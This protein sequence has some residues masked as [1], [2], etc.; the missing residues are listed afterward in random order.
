MLIEPFDAHGGLCDATIYQRPL[1]RDSSLRLL[2]CHV[3]TCRSGL[4]RHQTSDLLPPAKQQRAQDAAAS[5]LQLAPAYSA[6]RLSLVVLD[7]LEQVL[8]TLSACFHASTF[9]THRSL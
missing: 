9:N 4:V 3:H 7:M 1:Q 8:Q 2:S 5:G 6:L